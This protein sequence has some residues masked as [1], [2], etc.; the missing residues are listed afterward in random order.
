MAIQQ[1]LSSVAAGGTLGASDQY[2]CLIILSIAAQF[3]L[4]TL[5]PEIG[6]VGSIGFTVFITI[7]WILTVLPAYGTLLSPGVLN[8]VN[9]TV[10][11]LSGVFVPASGALLAIATAETTINMHAEA[12]Y[13]A[14][15]NSLSAI[16]G[17]GALMASI[18]TFLKFLIKPGLGIVTGT[19]GTVSAPI[20]KTVENVMSVVL[21]GLAYLLLSINPWLLFI[22]AAMIV[23]GL[24]IV[25][26][27]VIY[28]LWQLGKGVG[29]IIR[30]FQANPKVGLSVIVE[31]FVWGMGWMILKGWRNGIYRLLLW[32]LCAL[33]IVVFFPLILTPISMMIPPLFMA[34]PLIQILLGGMCVYLIGFR[35][36]KS[37]LETVEVTKTSVSIEK[38][39]ASA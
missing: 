19:A 3:D 7:I 34:I 27:F 36:A 8:F 20:Y 29:K 2:L 9:T 35:S 13:T 37:L 22:F 6:F 16:G 24:V 18:V 39:S 10:G 17:G 38:A 32:A 25:L 4:A 11:A 1:I 15:G 30:I 5:P 21:M 26:A 23:V 14:I 31:V 28:K 33:T 12:G